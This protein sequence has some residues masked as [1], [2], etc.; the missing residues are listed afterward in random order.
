MIRLSTSFTV[1]AHILFDKK[2]YFV[3]VYTGNNVG[4]MAYITAC[5]FD[6]SREWEI[7]KIYYV[8]ARRVVTMHGIYTYCKCLMVCT[9]LLYL[10]IHHV[11]H[12]R[13]I[14]GM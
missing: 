9:C 2:T 12:K 11:V 3:Y 10:N 13:S 1:V 4:D 8:A 6:N 7:S 5:K 14:F